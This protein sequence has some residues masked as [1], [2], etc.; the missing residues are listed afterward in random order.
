MVYSRAPVSTRTE[1][2]CRRVREE[3]TMSIHS[4]NIAGLIMNGLGTL[5]LV[6]SPPPN[7]PREITSDGLEKHSVTWASGFPGSGDTR[8]NRFKYHMRLYG[9]RIG[10]GFLVV[11]FLLQLVAEILR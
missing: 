2:F 8:K 1:G 10:L 4:L 7:V 11:G 3:S 6:F 5:I 9:F